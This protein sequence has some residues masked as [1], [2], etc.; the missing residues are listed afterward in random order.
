[1]S[2]MDNQLEITIVPPGGSVPLR[3]FRVSMVRLSISETQ[4]DMQR[5]LLSE[6]KC[7]LCI[8]QVIV[9]P[10]SMERDSRDLVSG[11]DDPIACLSAS[12]LLFGSIRAH[13]SL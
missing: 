6:M 10:L 4:G 2:R 9:L 1:M 13:R 8:P 7:R 12:T 11:K 5:G 3:I